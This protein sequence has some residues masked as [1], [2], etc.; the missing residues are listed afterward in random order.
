LEAYLRGMAVAH[1]D[2]QRDVLAELD[3]RIGT[4]P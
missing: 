4:T 1:N 3:R 2:E